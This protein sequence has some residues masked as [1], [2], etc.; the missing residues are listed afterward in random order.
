MRRFCQVGLEL[1]YDLI[2]SM[3]IAEGL[4]K[5]KVAD[6]PEPGIVSIQILLPPFR[7]RILPEKG[8]GL[9]FA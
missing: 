4:L 6:Y 1:L 3:D 5:G 7:N 8:R 9:I 2:S